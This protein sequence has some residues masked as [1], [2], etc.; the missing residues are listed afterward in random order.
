MVEPGSG[1]GVLVAQA[2]LEYY[3]QDM[4]DSIHKTSTGEKQRD[5]LERIVDIFNNRLALQLQQ[6]GRM[7]PF[8]RIPLKYEP[9]E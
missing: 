4:L 6:A 2:L 8:I 5:P 3:T 7:L 1:I 9:V